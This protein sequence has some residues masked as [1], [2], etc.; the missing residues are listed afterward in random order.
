MAVNRENHLRNI[1][2]LVFGNDPREGFTE[3]SRFFHPTLQF[4]IAFPSG[5]QIENTRSAVV[6][7]APQQGA[8]LQLSVAKTPAGTTPAG[9]A[10]ALAARGLVPQRS[11]ELRINGNDAFLGLYAIRVQ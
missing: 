11:E 1:D 3:G 5:W 9:Y 4:Q 6:A 7:L 2:G 8:Q 10:R